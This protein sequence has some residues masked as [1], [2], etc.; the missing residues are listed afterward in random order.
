MFH[1][2][3]SNIYQIGNLEASFNPN[4][5]INIAN[6]LDFTIM[7]LIHI[8]LLVYTHNVILIYQE[9]SSINDVSPL[10][11]QYLLNWEFISIL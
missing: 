5:Q 2:Y 8:D 10:Y 4:L 6:K 3:T 11:N 7:Q 1:H 9:I